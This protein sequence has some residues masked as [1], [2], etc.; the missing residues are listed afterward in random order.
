MVIY[1]IF[2]RNRAR[3]RYLYWN[4]KHCVQNEWDFW[5][6]IKKKKTSKKKKKKKN[7]NKTLTKVV[8]AK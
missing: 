7:G 3:G 6:K 4:N 5:L 1:V 2:V 8:N